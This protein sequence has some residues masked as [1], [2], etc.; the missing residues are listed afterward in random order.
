MAPVDPVIVVPGITASYLRD[1]YPV[2]AEHVW[3]VIQKRYERIALHPDDLDYEAIEPARVRADQVFEVAYEELI[4][5]LR[6]NLSP[7]SD[8]PVPVFAFSY[9]WRK[10]LDEIEESLAAFVDEV[11]GRTKLLGHYHSAGYAD[12]PRVHLVGHSMGGLAITGYLDAIGGKA[13]VNKVVTLATP[14]QGSF[15]AVIKVITGT[16][17]LGTKAPSSRERE[18]ARLTPALYHLLPSFSNAVSAEPGIPTSLF[19]AKAWQSTVVDSISEFIRLRGLPLK[20]RRKK[21]ERQKDAAALFAKMLTLA[22]KHRARI[23]RFQLSKAGMQAG[24]WL[25][26]IGAGAE[27]RVGLKIESR[28]GA[29]QFMLSSEDRQDQWNDADPNKARRT[30]DGTVPFEGAIPKFLDESQ[31]VCVTPDDYGYWEVED[32]ALTKVAGFHGLLPNM[33]MLHRLI[34]RFFTGAPDRRGNT[35]GHPV[36]GVKKWEPPLKLT[37]K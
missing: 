35:W 14:Y 18:A 33:N 28:R 21:S 12:N 36:P 29:P 3:K 31:L 15:E 19:N 10:P 30:G 11:I 5:E 2:P 13:P 32:R 26:V 25:A 1:E 17:N 37:K 27:T 6:Y 16:A 22:R 7:S 8:S 34:V 4:E 9:D 20:G 24:D 23:D